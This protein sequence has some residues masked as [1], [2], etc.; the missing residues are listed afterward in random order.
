[1]MDLLYPV[2]Y[3]TPMTTNRLRSLLV[4]FCALLAAACNAP[5]RT[6]QAERAPIVLAAASLQD[7]LEEAAQTWEAQG[8]AR[9]ALSFA[10]SSALARQIENGAPADLFISADEEWM[11]ELGRKGLLR[12]GTRQTLLGNAL[13]L[14]APAGSR[15]EVA[16]G[17]SMELPLAL[18]ANGRLAIADPETVP[19]GK[20]AKAALE[21]LGIWAAVSN[22][23]APA[24]N[25]RAALALVERGEVPL[26]VVYR[27]DA[28]VTVKARLVARFP[29]DSHPPIRY[30]A[31]V[32]KAS[33]NADAEA[34]LD[35]L[36]SPEARAIFAKYG[37][38]DPQ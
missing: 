38:T 21:K 1:M 5:S 25:V 35:F 19:A 24:E 18:G 33:D 32:L 30:P 14:V 29:A 13:V 28:L 20:Y 12:E 36:A 7:A 9:P 15:A 22:R 17:N 11:D 16:L 37:F 2:Q 8:H 27:T 10:A 23:V 31:A 3:S 4:A 34:F 26:G 6:E